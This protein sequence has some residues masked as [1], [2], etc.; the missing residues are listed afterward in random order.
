MPMIIEKDYRDSAGQFLNSLRGVSYPEYKANYPEGMNLKPGSKLHTFIVE[1][2]LDR[3]RES[4][5][6]MSTKHDKWR[7]IDEM[8]T[9]FIPADDAELKRQKRDSR[10]PI[11]IVVPELYSIRETLLA[12]LMSVYGEGPLFSYSGTGPEDTLGAILL[13]KVIETQAKKSK[14]LLALLTSWSDSLTYGIGAVAA[15]WK[16]KTGTRSVI[17][18]IGYTD[19]ISGR[20]IPTDRRKK[21]VP[22]VTFEGA[23][24]YPIDPYLLLPDPNR[25]IYD[26]QSMEYFGWKTSDQ[27]NVLRREEYDAEFGTF[28]IQYLR[29]QHTRSTIYSADA[30]GLNYNVTTEDEYCSKAQP[31]DSIYMYVDLIPKEWG[32]GGSTLPEKW[33]FRVSGDTVVTMAHQIDFDE[34][35][36]AG[37]AP[38]ASGHEIVPISRLELM[39]GSQ[40]AAN[41]QHNSHMLATVLGLSNRLVFDPEIL[42][43]RDVM[44]EIP[45]HPIRS[46][47][48]AWGS[49]GV[50]D[51]FAQLQS[52]DITRGHVADLATTREMMKELSGATSA[53]QGIQRQGGERVTATEFESTRGGALSR[54]GVLAKKISLQGMMDMGHIV[55][56]M[57]QDF[58]TE[59]TY[60]KVAGTWE[61]VLRDIH[62]FKDPTIAVSPFDLLI[63]YDIIPSDGTVL[64]D[65]SAQDWNNLFAVVAKNPE[66]SQTLDT[67]RIFMHMARL[68]GAKNVEDFRRKGGG[69]GMQTL[70]NQEIVQQQ[71]AGNIVPMGAVQ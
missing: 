39:Y 8:N 46:R 55:A 14:M 51:A 50:K 36:V 9:A 62:G 38:D 63:N 27:Y 67:T 53:L 25:P 33:L 12:Y 45:G 65:E 2:V 64:G 32:F 70:P 54:L 7:Q 44:S 29:G 52:S 21:R 37:F 47:Q 4:E 1:E 60:V 42:N 58:M 31:V 13:E 5:R 15:R 34:F 17:E 16:V 43:S 20:L 49:G 19:P 48:A 66:L 10:T 56:K 28:N 69:A 59:E 35:P 23:E 40:V 68:M 71:Q 30:S 26:I 22:A 6:F 18:D 57:T 41:F 3:A 24:L 11:S 61:A